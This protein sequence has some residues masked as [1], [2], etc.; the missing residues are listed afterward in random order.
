[1][2][3]LHPHVFMLQS[4]LSSFREVV[5][6]LPVCT[7]N[8]ESLHK[9]LKEVIL[10]LEKIGFRVLVVSDNNSINR[11]ALSMFPS[12]PKLR[13]AHPNPADALQP[14]FYVVDAVH[15]LKYIRNNWLNR[16]NP[17]S[18][19]Y[20][21][22]FDLSMNTAHHD[23]I[24]W[25]LFK[26]LRELHKLETS[27]LLKY[28]Y[29]LSSKALNPSNL[30]RQNV[31]LALQVFNEFV[32]EALDAHS[33]LPAFLHAKETANFV[34]IIVQWW[35]IVDVKT[36]HKGYHHRDVYE[37][38]VSCLTDDPKLTFLDALMT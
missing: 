23:P 35:K 37:Q 15:L 3:P 33:D 16:K 4:M 1:M 36:P 12:P 6:I 21:P 14:L 34:K 5:H 27:Q 38:P 20:F 25:A 22:L 28:S 26:E 32:A 18:N 10:G 8:A 7:L 19:L 29:H 13:I 11:K 24:Q 17:A 9:V 2:W 31:K 30:E